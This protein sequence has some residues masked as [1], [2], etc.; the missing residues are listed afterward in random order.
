MGKLYTAGELYVAGELCGG[1][2]FG[3]GLAFDGVGADVTVAHR[4][5]RYEVAK[6]SCGP[7]TFPLAETN[8]SFMELLSLSLSSYLGRNK[9]D[10][11]APASVAPSVTLAL[12]RPW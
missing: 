10:V 5:R 8:V 2:V 7:E 11:G 1:G 6:R 9:R 3:W 4:I 12:P